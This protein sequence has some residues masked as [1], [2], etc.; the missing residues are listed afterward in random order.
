MT[1][2]NK[3]SIFNIVPFGIFSIFKFPWKIFVVK[4]STVEII[5]GLNIEKENISLKMIIDNDNN[6]H[7]ICVV[8]NDP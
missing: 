7:F 1:I 6:P 5:L 8:I 3:S 4:R 2:Q